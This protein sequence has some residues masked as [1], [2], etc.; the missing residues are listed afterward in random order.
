M[1]TK[2]SHSDVRDKY[3]N[4]LLSVQY[5]MSPVTLAD[6]IGVSTF[7]AHEM[8]GQHHE[9]FAQYWTWSDDYVAHAL[10]TGV[11]QTVF[12]W[13]HHVGI[14][15]A[16]NERSL[17]NWPVQATGADILRIACILAKRHGIKLLAPVHDAVLIEA[18][19]DRIEADVALIQEI[20]RRASR[21][22]L[23]ATVEGTHELRTEANI[24]RYPAHYSDKRG[25][26]IWDH[27][28]GL[29]AKQEQQGSGG[30]K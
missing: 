19:D 5:G 28:I 16:V 25:D 4:M 14:I 17:R 22:V 9:L 18:P 20:M 3:K 13:T 30:P 12:G 15:G 11:V 2:Q 26:A 1:A 23:N 10:Q 24:V 6:R 21:I 29:L 7:E 8:L 27:V